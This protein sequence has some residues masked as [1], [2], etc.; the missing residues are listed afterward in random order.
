MSMKCRH[1]GEQTTN[2]KF[3]SLS[4]SAKAQSRTKKQKTRTCLNCKIEFDYGRD[5][6]KKFCTSSCA[7]T[8]N[9]QIRTRKDARLLKECN[10]C[11]VQTYNP[12]FCSSRCSGEFKTLAIID[13]WKRDPQSGTTKHGLSQT[14]RNYLI[15]QSGYQCSVCGWDKINYSTGKSPLEIDHINGD[16]FDNHLNNL[17]VLC[18]N[19]HSLTPTYKALNK[20][21]KR[22]YR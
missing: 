8:Y 6:K 19:C 16:C 17:R 21:S 5:P 9:N 7:A 1:C 3:C 11:G 18:P 14:I 10:T 20:K 13:K 15:E 4:C 12:K 2:V 22:S